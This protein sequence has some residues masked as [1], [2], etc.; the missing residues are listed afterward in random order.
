MR[1]FNLSFLFLF[2][3]VSIGR[4]SPCN[5]QTKNDSSLYYYQAI[6]DPKKPEDRPDGINFYT[7]KK[8]L[9][10]KNHDTLNVIHDLRML[11]IGEFEIGNYYDSENH[12]VEALNL[13][14]SSVYKDTM[15]SARVGLYNQLGRIYRASNNP[16]EAIQA[17][18]RALKIAINEKDSVILLNNKANIL[19]DQ[20]LYEE[21]ISIYR[22]LHQKSLDTKD[23][24]Q[25]ALVLDNLGYSQ[26]KIN[27]PEALSN[28]FEALEIRKDRKYL[29]GIYSSYRH[30]AEYY[31]LHNDKKNASIYA[32]R[33]FETAEKINSNSFKLDALSLQMM[34]DDN[35]RV[36]T[37][38]RLSDS[39]SLAKQ[40]AENKNAYLK[41]NVSQEQ[42]KTEASKLL[43]EIES[44]K[45][46]RY[47]FL[48]LLIFLA[49]IASYF[50]FRYRQKQANLK[51]VYNTE[52]RISKKVHDEV[53][54]DLYKVMTAMDEKYGENEQLLDE[55]EK[56]YV[57]T[58]DISREN[59]SLDVNDDFESLLNDLFFGYKGPD[60]QIVTRN[61]SKINWKPI[62]EVKKRTIYRV[63]QELL[64]NMKKHSK[65]TSVALV[66]I[67]KGS[68]IQINY[69]DNGVGCD[70]KHK[71]GLQNTETRITSING[72]I[73]FESK[74][75]KGFKATIIV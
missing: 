17:Y 56:I 15:V 54:N 36:V 27:S 55:M 32:E 19:K 63:L 47:Q 67:K 73:S 6:V 8:Q 68:K 50:I 11:A 22:Y 62:A 29:S 58:R 52:T 43:Q 34:L 60:V 13:I 42:K 65:A 2:I 41:Y 59:R 61:L 3:L 51:A 45:R 69:S 10:V 74:E 64:T 16:S 66:F 21:A 38:K 48:S 53:A 4:V 33:A 37:Y 28:L 1:L 35:P 49:L 70:L 25:V 14:N 30:I 71:N 31:I 20:E 23:T 40:I 26:S 44:Q 57:K 9:D 39:A 75:N 5:A 24:L 46:Q 12:I 18:D 72:T 7:K